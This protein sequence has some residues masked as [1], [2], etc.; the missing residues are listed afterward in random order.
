MLIFFGQVTVT[1]T[2]V[3]DVKPASGGMSQVGQSKD[4]SL[5]QFLECNQALFSLA[6]TSLKLIIQLYTPSQCLPSP[7]LFELPHLT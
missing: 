2:K 4:P 7:C 6:P 3:G 1:T 5:A